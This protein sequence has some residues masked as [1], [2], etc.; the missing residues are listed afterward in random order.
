M[1]E[2]TLSAQFLFLFFISNSP[3]SICIKQN[4]DQKKLL[5][6]FPNYI[7]CCFFFLKSCVTFPLI[8]PKY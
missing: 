7:I 5:C 2:T 3:Y 1:R 6:T 8:T 4:T